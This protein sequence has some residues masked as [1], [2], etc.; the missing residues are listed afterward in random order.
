M[1]RKI[2]LEVCSINPRRSYF[3]GYLDLGGVITHWLKSCPSNI[4]PMFKPGLEINDM[5]N[6]KQM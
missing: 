1:L 6:D 3:W 4:Q 5:N 2:P